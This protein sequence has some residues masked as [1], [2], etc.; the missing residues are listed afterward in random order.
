MEG[1]GRMDFKFIIK[2]PLDFVC[3]E[4]FADGFEI[5]IPYF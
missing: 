5:L 2:N 4:G 3:I 1:F